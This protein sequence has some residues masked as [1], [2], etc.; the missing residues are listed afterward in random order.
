MPE[1]T[2]TLTVYP[3]PYL[4]FDAV[5]RPASAFPHEP[6]FVG[7]L[8]ADTGVHFVGSTR[9]MGRELRAAM[10]NL[11]AHHEYVHH[12]G[13]Q[14]EGAPAQAVPADAS[15]APHP[16]TIVEN[17]E[18]YRRAIRSHQLFAADLA[19]WLAAGGAAELYQ[20]PMLKL[21]HAQEGLQAQHVAHY[22]EKSPHIES[23]WADLHAAT[24]AK[25]APKPGPQTPPLPMPLKAS[26]NTTTAG[27]QES[28]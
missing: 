10:P 2:R 23:H 16:P 17:S 3:N 12:F 7:G 21:A 8:P 25:N 9:T 28:K 4:A 27:S 6:Q 15:R 1:I 20:D 19:T 13:P 22:G 5:G 11:T 14:P 18:Y 24:R 26:G